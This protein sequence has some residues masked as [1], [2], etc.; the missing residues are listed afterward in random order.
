VKV[1]VLHSRD[2]DGNEI[3]TVPLSNIDKKVILYKD[4]F[5]ELLSLGVVPKWT[6][7]A[8]LVLARG[9]MPIGRLIVDAKKG[10]KV[11]VLDG[12][13]LNL[14]RSNLFVSLGNAK[15]NARDK[16]SNKPVHRLMVENVELE[17]EH[18]LPSWEVAEALRASQ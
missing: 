10:E 12:S 15:Y 11:E 2:E 17:H 18:K 16:L 4:D 5:N 1:R 6:L 8:N 13:P 3:V 14:R 9:R 7:N